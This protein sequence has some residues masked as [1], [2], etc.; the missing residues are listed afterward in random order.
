MSKPQPLLQEGFC[1][2]SQLP[3][4]HVILQAWNVRCRGRALTP[5]MPA[6]GRQRCGGGLRSKDWMKLMLPCCW[7]IGVSLKLVFLRAN[8]S[9]H[10]RCAGQ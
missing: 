10:Q 1:C 7:E 5:T 6:H 4:S 8:G 3:T 9:S 2:R